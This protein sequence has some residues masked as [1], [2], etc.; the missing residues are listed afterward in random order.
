[1][2]I[3]YKEKSLDGLKV[4]DIKAKIDKAYKELDKVKAKSKRGR[5]ALLKQ[6]VELKTIEGLTEYLK[7]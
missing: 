3:I 2:N 1:M 6:L 5:K 4:Q 7:K